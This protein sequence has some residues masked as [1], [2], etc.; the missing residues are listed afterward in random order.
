MID[1][2]CDVLVP[3]T[4]YILY[5]HHMKSGKMFGDLDDYEKKNFYEWIP[6]PGHGYILTLEEE[7]QQLLEIIEQQ[8]CFRHDLNNHLSCISGLLDVGDNI[9]AKEYLQHIG[10]MGRSKKTHYYSSRNILNVLFNQKAALA[11]ALNVDFD[12]FIDDV[13]LSFMEDYDVCTLLGNLLDNGLESAQLA[14]D[15]YLTFDLHLDKQGNVV[16]NMRN[17]CVE[18]PLIVDRQFVSRKK[19]SAQHGKGMKNIQRVAEKYHGEF[20][21]FY[22]EQEKSFHTHIIFMKTS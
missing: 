21:Y 8:R 1:K 4:N 11:E 5:G 20:S 14:E 10:N 12:V 9:K 18:G 19:D 2:D 7:N 15:A 13:D 17:S 22:H 3:S 6:D 16:L